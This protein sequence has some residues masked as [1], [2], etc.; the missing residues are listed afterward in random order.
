MINDFVESVQGSTLEYMD[1]Q[2][3]KLW[4]NYIV[5]KFEYCHSVGPRP[6]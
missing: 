1:T 6:V 5:F 3:H 2:G 4:E